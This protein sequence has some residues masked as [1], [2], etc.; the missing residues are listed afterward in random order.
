MYHPAAM[1]PLD[2]LI[3]ARPALVAT[4]PYTLVHLRLVRVDVY[5]LV[6]D[7]PLLVAAAVYSYV[8]V[9]VLVLVTAASLA[10]VV[11]CLCVLAA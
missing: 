3:A 5:H 8:S 10:V 9:L 7:R 1:L 2:R 4:C 6:V 11:M